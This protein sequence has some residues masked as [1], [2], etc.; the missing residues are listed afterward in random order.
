MFQETREG[1]DSDSWVQAIMMNETVR[2]IRNP[3][4]LTSSEQVPASCQQ[5]STSAVTK[6][7]HMQRV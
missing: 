1:L 4:S 7:Y 3:L 5:C 2:T 6:S